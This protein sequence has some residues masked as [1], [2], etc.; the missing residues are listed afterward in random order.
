FCSHEDASNIS[1]FWHG[2]F[3]VFELLIYVEDNQR[4]YIAQFESNRNSLFFIRRWLR[5]VV[6][7]MY[8][9]QETISPS[10]MWIDV[11]AHQYGPYASIH[12]GPYK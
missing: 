12:E 11:A 6:R 4:E 7:R 10:Y 3:K 1:F 8:G 2:G 9:H 5:N